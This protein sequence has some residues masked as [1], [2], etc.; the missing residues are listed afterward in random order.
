MDSI[1]ISN[2]YLQSKIIKQLFLTPFFSFVLG[3]IIFC[4]AHFCVYMN[5]KSVLII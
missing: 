5:I 3:G 4:N 2:I 1:D